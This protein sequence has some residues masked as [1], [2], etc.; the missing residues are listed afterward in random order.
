MQS[1]VTFP[2]GTPTLTGEHR[3]GSLRLSDAEVKAA[4][5]KAAA[6][7][8][9]IMKAALQRA[10]AHMYTALVDERIKAGHSASAA[11]RAVNLAHP[12]LAASALTGC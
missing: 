8:A 5:L 7:T 11:A 9:K 6:E 3:S 1:N 10:N 12:E 2:S 4:R